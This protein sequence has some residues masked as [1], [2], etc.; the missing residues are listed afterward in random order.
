[1]IA[2]ALREF[3]GRVNCDPFHISNEDLLEGL[4]SLL[5]EFKQLDNYDK[6]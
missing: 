2:N 6:K 1:M 3:D 5:D 4:E